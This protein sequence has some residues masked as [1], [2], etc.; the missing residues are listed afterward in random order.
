MIKCPS[1]VAKIVILDEADSM[2]LAAQQSLRR[3]MEQFSETTRFAFAVNDLSKMLE[4][5]QSRCGVLHFK[6]L[7]DDDIIKRLITVC[8]QEG[9]KAEYSG[10]EAI[11]FTSNG[12]MRPALNH[13]QV[14]IAN[15]LKMEEMFLD[16]V[17]KF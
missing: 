11:A 4:A 9:V 8:K 13:L 6:K 2:T 5:I 12:D 1:K 16:G 14:P 17:C 10:L 15:A 7:S 3:I